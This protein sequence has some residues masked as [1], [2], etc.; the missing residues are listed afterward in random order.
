[1]RGKSSFQ[2]VNLGPIKSRLH[3]KSNG[4]E[5]KTS[6]T[7]YR[8]CM[9]MLYKQGRC[10]L[11]GEFPS[12]LSTQN[13]TWKPSLVINEPK[14]R[15]SC[16]IFMRHPQNASL[17]FSNELG[18]KALGLSTYFCLSIAIDVSNLNNHLLRSAVFFGSK[19][20]IPT[21]PPFPKGWHS[22][23]HLARQYFLLWLSLY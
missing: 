22:M 13:C 1:M 15:K 16:F 7:V 18:I 3:D 5:L 20:L 10:S 12:H 8:L 11:K 6:A 17:H 21:P 14:R 23:L 4:D 9:A 2:A 19:S